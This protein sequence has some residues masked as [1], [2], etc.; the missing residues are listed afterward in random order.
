VQPEADKN[1]EGDGAG[2]NTRV[3]VSITTTGGDTQAE[4]SVVEMATA[5][6]AVICHETKI[7]Q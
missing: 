4:V 2:R 6:A 7:H 1:P 3:E 5:D